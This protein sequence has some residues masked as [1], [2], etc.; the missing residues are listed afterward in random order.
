MPLTG[1]RLIDVQDAMASIDSVHLIF[2]I[3]EAGSRS[4]SII[5]EHLV[6]VHY[7]LCPNVGNLGRNKLF[8]TQIVKLRYLLIECSFGHS[9]LLNWTLRKT[10]A[11]ANVALR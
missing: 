2:L 7:W 3:V 10:L 11:H 1:C 5:F 4:F 6:G 9:T 8:V